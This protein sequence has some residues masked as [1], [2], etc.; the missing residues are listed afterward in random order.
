MCLA[1]TSAIAHTV[2]GALQKGQHDQWLTRTS[3]DLW[4]FVFAAPL[5]LSDV[6]W[7]QG[8]EWAVL[9]GALSIH[10][11]CKLTMA[12]ACERAAY[13]VVYPVVRGTGQLATPGFAAPFLDEHYRALQ[14]GG[15]ACCRGRS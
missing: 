10:F 9:P 7:L 6:P 2:F 8:G 5:A 11:A 3:I 12:L 1:L 15:A 4:T 14:R 13:P